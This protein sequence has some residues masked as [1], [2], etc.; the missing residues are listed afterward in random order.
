MELKFEEM[1]IPSAPVFN[2][3]EIKAEIS[4]KVQKYET[5]VYT[6]EQIRDAKKD[7]AALNKLKKALNDERLKRER[8]FI[9]PFIEFKAQVA[10]LVNIIDKPIALIDAQVKEY[11]E[12]RKREKQMEIGNL[13][14]EMPN[15]PEW[16]QLKQI[17][18]DSWL[19]ATE[20]LSS[21]KDRLSGW[22][23]RANE[24][25][26]TLESM[27][28]IDIEAIDTY[29]ITLDLN[30]AI[31]EGKRIADMRKRRE[32][33]ELK[34]KQEQERQEQAQEAAKYMMPP[35]IP[36]QMPKAA[37]TPEKPAAQWIAFRAMLTI[38]QA[39]ELK[40]FF[41]SRGIP[42]EPVKGGA[43]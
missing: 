23:A 25:I 28:D 26:K 10:E 6:D 27:P 31:A 2:F 24:D 30:R 32:E 34:R 8:E 22:I 11:D 41:Q 18:E 21:I 14:D 4:E 38:P 35:E 19:N 42:F 12:K 13:W 3:S 33:A 7:R 9:Q 40:A 5:L 29:K 43:S 16:L 17:F 1:I 15:K 37:E 39:L 36:E 20:K